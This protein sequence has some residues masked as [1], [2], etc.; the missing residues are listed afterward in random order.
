MYVFVEHTALLSLWQGKRLSQIFKWVSGGSSIPSV[1]EACKSQLQSQFWL[2]Y[3]S[4]RLAEAGFRHY[5]SCNF[6]LN[7]NSTGTSFLQNSIWKNTALFFSFHFFH[8]SL[9]TYLTSVDT[10]M[11]FW[12]VPMHQ[13]VLLATTG[14]LNGNEHI[15]E[16]LTWDQKTASS[17]NDQRQSSS[18]GTIIDK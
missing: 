7:I 3:I 9:Y 11:Q 13:A 5:S 17:R 15:E 14:H 10:V 8:Y 18:L 4:S 1:G 12:S 6:E 16:V 2:N